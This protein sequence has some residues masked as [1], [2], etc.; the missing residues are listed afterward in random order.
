MVNLTDRQSGKLETVWMD[1]KTQQIRP[2]EGY[3]MPEKKKGGPL[4]EVK[5]PGGQKMGLKPIL[6]ALPETEQQMQSEAASIGS[7][8][9]AK[10]LLEKHGDEITGFTGSAKRFLAPY[11]SAIG[12][13]SEEL[14]DAE[15]FKTITDK[16]AGS[17]RMEVVGPGPVSEFEQKILQ[18]VSGGK[19]SYAKGAAQL[20]DYFIDTKGKKIEKYNERLG[21][22]AKQEGLEYIPEIYKQVE[23]PSPEA[24]NEPQEVETQ[25]QYDALKSGDKYIVDGIKYEKK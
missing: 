10:G 18:N 14:S 4:V 19:M 12:I 6:D 20:L 15:M 2:V 24:F 3:S 8:Q 22:L 13:D 25:E 16:T 17:F 7:L 9:T 5:M 23:I 21:N 1:P 11:A